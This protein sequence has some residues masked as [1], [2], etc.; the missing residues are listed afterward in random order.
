MGPASMPTGYASNSFNTHARTYIVSID[1]IQIHP[2]P[3]NEQGTT[4][5]ASFPQPGDDVLGRLARSRRLHAVAA[6][7][8]G[9]TVKTT[10]TTSSTATAPTDVDT[11]QLHHVQAVFKEPQSSYAFAWHQGP[12]RGRGAIGR[13]IQSIYSYDTHA[14]P[15]PIAPRRL[16]LPLPRRHPAAAHVHAGGGRRPLPPRERRPRDSGALPHLRPVRTCMC[17]RHLLF[18]CTII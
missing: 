9:T 11:T 3:S 8:I 5:M 12:S 15:S 10:P 18:L 2:N 6:A 4:K 16:R 13:S 7:A 14:S 1:P 17:A